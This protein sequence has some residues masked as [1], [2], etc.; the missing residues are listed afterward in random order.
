MIKKKNFV[1]IAAS[2]LILIILGYLFFN[3]PTRYDKTTCF[4]M[5]EVTFPALMDYVVLDC[6]GYIYIEKDNKCSDD[7]PEIE[8]KCE[9]VFI[10]DTKNYNDIVSIVDD[11]KIV[12]GKFYI[13]GRLGLSN[14]FGDAGKKYTFYHLIKDNEE[15]TIDFTD[16]T[17]IPK[18]IVIDSNVTNTDLYKDY[19]EMPEETKIIFQSLENK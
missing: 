5:P 6:V 13:I 8:R 1:A 15:A 3:W 18:Y 12:D 11:Y 19:S 16:D 7:I 10:Y 14:L 4:N 17:E 9:D 2:S